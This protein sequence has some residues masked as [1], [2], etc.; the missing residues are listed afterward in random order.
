M[1]KIRMH[2]TKAFHR[3]GRTVRAGEQFEAT[4][5][6]AEYLERRG[7][8]IRLPENT[9]TGPAE[10]QG[11]DGPREPAQEPGPAETQV[12]AGPAEIKELGGGWFEVRGEKIQ[13]R[14]AAEEAAKSEA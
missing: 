4:P 2:C 10:T 12:A 9:A 8:A 6:V 5:D 1:S 14:E 3:L 11:Q 13:G 7:R